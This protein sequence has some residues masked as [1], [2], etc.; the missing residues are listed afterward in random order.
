[1]TEVNL[2]R[3]DE[4]E[5]RFGSSVLSRGIVSLSLRISS[6]FSALFP[7]FV[8][9][10][11]SKRT[12]PH[13]IK[14]KEKNPPAFDLLRASVNLMVSSALIALG[15]SLKLPLSTTY[16]TF[17]VAMGTSLSDGAWDRETAVYRVTGVVSVIGGWFFTAFSA[18]T[19]A[20]I[21]ASLFIWGGAVV[22]FIMI[23][24]ALYTAYR[25]HKIHLKK[26]ETVKASQ[27][28]EES[29]NSSNVKKY[30]VKNT[31]DILSKV[32]KYYNQIITGTE[33]TSLSDIKD[34]RKKIVLMQKRTRIQRKI[35]SQILKGTNEKEGDQAYFAIRTID[36]LLEI[37]NCIDVVSNTTYVHL[38]NHH[39]PLNDNQLAEL[40]VISEKLELMLN[41]ISQFVSL[42]ENS[43]MVDPE[44]SKKSTETEIEA[45]SR[46][47]VRRIR[48][49]MTGN[50]SSIL[51][52]SILQETR[53]IVF[54]STQVMQNLVK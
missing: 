9:N 2:S 53:N 8:K 38:S 52:M 21:L 28:E 20:F 36:N 44:L 24:V 45:S 13:P 37:I 7:Q 27:F 1:M 42:E 30:C 15:T 16:V 25:T 39:K 34:V 22:I 54:F 33:G 29:V 5:E 26:E 43:E 14:K 12:T 17:M 47:E 19:I 10:W 11:L 40:K 46:N 48:E 49:Q 31:K 32:I 51:F 35:V 41:E 6:F 18:F 4:G 3:Q 50:R 23:L